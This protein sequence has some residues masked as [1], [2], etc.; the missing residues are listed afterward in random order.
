MIVKKGRMTASD[1]VRL[2]YEVP[3]NVKTAEATVGDNYLLLN[4]GTSM[5]Q[6]AVMGSKT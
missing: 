5:N 2:W 4:G 1:V 3:R 6:E